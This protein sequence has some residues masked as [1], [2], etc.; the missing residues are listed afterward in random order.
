MSKNYLTDVDK[1]VKD[2]NNITPLELQSIDLEYLQ[3]RR[4]KNYLIIM[5]VFESIF[6]ARLREIT[7]IFDKISFPNKVFKCYSYLAI[8]LSGSDYRDHRLYS[9]P[10]NLDL[11]GEK[12]MNKTYREILPQIAKGG[13]SIKNELTFRLNS[14]VFQCTKPTSLQ[15]SSN[16]Y[17]EI[18]AEREM[19]FSIDEFIKRYVTV[20]ASNI[21]VEDTYYSYPKITKQSLINDI[22]CTCVEN[23]RELTFACR[24]CSNANDRSN[25]TGHHT[26]R[27]SCG[28]ITYHRKNNCIKCHLIYSK[29]RHIK[30]PFYDDGTF[31]TSHIQEFKSLSGY[32]PYFH[33]N[34]NSGGICLG[35]GGRIISE[36][37]KRELNPVK[38][39]LAFKANL[40]Y[41]DADNTKSYYRMY[42]Q[43]LQS[44]QF[45]NNLEFHGHLV[46]TF[47]SKKNI[48]KN[49]TFSIRCYC[50]QCFY[51]RICLYQANM[52]LDPRGFEIDQPYIVSRDQF[53]EVYKHYI[54]NIKSTSYINT[55]IHKI[56]KIIANMQPTEF[57]TA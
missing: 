5:G 52:K 45:D 3:V 18:K 29:A 19:I 28:N 44:K 10:I 51:Y 15:Y 55:Y 24:T 36:M 8:D 54:E 4:V 34:Q 20:E 22:P 53:I 50:P 14:N 47:R 48:R 1:M 30:T 40:A 39:M 9:F 17:I 37:V 43:K 13:M 27:C 25:C 32:I 56:I 31:N 35:G 23:A 12:K 38:I 16:Y 2:I 33:Y 11:Y 6:L 41:T 42:V 46:N 49:H 26:K 21:R 57:L 7:S